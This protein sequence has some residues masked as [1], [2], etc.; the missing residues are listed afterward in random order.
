[1]LQF[2]FVHASI[3]FNVIGRCSSFS[4]SNI[5]NGSVVDVFREAR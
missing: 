3:K 2:D 1:M 5:L 4:S